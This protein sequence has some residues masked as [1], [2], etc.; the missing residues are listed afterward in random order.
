MGR[1]ILPTVE[2]FAIPGIGTALD[3]RSVSHDTVRAAKRAFQQVFADRIIEPCGRDLRLCTPKE[4][5]ERGHGGEKEISLVVSTAERGLA[6]PRV[7][8]M[9]VIYGLEIESEQGGVVEVSGFA[10]CGVA[11]PT[12][13]MSMGEVMRR[14]MTEILTRDMMLADG[15]RLDLVQWNFPTW[16]GEQ[17][18]DDP[19]ADHVVSELTLDGHDVEK[20]G[21]APRNARRQG[22]KR[23]RVVLQEVALP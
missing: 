19:V 14:V 6:K 17:W 7:L 11:P 15:R 22:V 5:R 13:R 2:T 16:P 9:M 20:T 10:A 4:Q 3:L 21:R 18:V 12:E 8:G 23:P 1:V